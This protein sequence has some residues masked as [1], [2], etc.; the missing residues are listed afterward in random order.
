MNAVRTIH[1]IKVLG[2]VIKIKMIL[3]IKM[4]ILLIEITPKKT[5]SNYN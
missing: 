4:M 5:K 1:L 2:N 3:I